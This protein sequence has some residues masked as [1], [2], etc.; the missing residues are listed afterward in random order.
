M[1]L[2]MFLFSNSCAKFVTQLWLF[3]VSLLVMAD[4]IIVS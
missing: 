4:T 1:I 2:Y 3:C